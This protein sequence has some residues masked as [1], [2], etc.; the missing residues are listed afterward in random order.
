M[1]RN[2]R[3]TIL[4]SFKMRIQL[5]HVFGYID[6]DISR[7][8]NNCNDSDT[9]A[10]MCWWLGCGSSFLMIQGWAK[11]IG[12]KINWKPRPPNFLNFIT[13]IYKLGCLSK[14]FF[15]N[16]HLTVIYKM[17]CLSKQFSKNLH[18][19]RKTTHLWLIVILM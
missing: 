12:R 3:A 9:N 7:W 2:L 17:G 18:N 5:P 6:I 1:S 14:Q 4:K 8:A 15:K 13:I 19:Q 11:R 16:L 10:G